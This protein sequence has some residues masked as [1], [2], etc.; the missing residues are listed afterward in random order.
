MALYCP[1]V[2][3]SGGHSAAPSPQQNA[4]PKPLGGGGRGPHL[5]NPF[6]SSPNWFRSQRRSG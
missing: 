6:S 1:S 3:Q 2:I 5:I 4:D